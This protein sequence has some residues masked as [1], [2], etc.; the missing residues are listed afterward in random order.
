MVIAKLSE[1]PEGAQKLFEHNGRPAIL[2]RYKGEL[3]C[4]VNVCP[5]AGGPTDLAGDQLVCEWHGSHFDPS[6]GERTAPPAPKGSKLQLI[7]IKVEG[8]E[9]VTVE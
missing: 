8:E 6:T 4:F 5:H 1:V 9:I 3:K 7:P 2:F